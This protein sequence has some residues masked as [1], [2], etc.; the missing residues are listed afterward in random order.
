M[1]IQPE[2]VLPD[3]VNSAI[4]NGIAIR[5]GT[6]AAFL[7]NSN[8]STEQIQAAIQMMRELAPAVIAL[9]LHKHVVFKNSQIEQILIDAEK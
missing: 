2:D 1:V 5:K 4:I 7:E 9:G 3:K 6:I 8:A